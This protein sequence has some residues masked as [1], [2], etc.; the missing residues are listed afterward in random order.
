MGTQREMITTADAQQKIW[1]LA[2]CANRTGMGKGP[3]GYSLK[4]N[5][6]FK[7]FQL[8]GFTIRIKLPQSLSSQL[9]HQIEYRCV[10]V[11]S[12]NPY[13]TV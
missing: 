6:Q 7:S 2:S 11:C 8:K 4:V 12:G 3:K 13:F 5:R 9:G 1:K 10:A